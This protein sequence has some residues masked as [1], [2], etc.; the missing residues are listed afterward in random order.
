MSKVFHSNY[1]ATITEHM[2]SQ[3]THQSNDSTLCG[4]L[5]SIEE[6]A[7]KSVDDLMLWVPPVVVFGHRVLLGRRK[8]CMYRCS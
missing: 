3:T 6:V 8:M 1:D 7:N 2:Q 4:E 5:S